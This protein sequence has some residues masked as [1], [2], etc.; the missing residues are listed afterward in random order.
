MSEATSTMPQ[1]LDDAHRDAL[2]GRREAGEL[3]L[4]ADDGEAAPVDLGAVADVVRAHS[5]AMA[6]GDSQGSAGT[7]ATAPFFSAS[8]RSFHGMMPSLD[9]A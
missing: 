7:R 1:A 4:G 8:G 3:G 5:A 6:G 9:S 2:L